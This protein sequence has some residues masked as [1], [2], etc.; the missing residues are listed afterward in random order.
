MIFKNINGTLIAGCQ[1]A[2]EF[3]QV[4][5]DE[6]ELFSLD[7]IRTMAQNKKMWPMLSDISKQVTWLGA[8]HDPETWKHIITAAWKAQVFVQG[9]GGTLVVIPART[10][11]MNKKE[12]SELI[13]AIYS[14]GSGEDVR[15]GEPA[16]AAYEEY[17]EAA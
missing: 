3:L 7:G 5:L 1:Q 11:R 6:V 16:L 10:S 4:C 13:E 14:F 15:W 12:F 9:I 8:K 17:R 2:H